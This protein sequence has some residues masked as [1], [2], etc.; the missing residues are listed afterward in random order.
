M[1]III[2]KETTKKTLEYTENN[3]SGTLQKARV[4][5]VEDS[6]GG[7]ME[8]KKVQKTNTKMAKVLPYQ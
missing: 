8:V 7:I 2:P 1:Q 6:N 3:K 5:K 4:N